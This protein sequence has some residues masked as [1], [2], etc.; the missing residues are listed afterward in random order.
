MRNRIAVDHEKHE[1]A[2]DRKGEVVQ[3]FNMII[4]C[5]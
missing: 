5:P 1:D 3:S 4:V 2:L